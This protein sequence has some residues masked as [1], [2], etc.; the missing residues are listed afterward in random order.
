MDRPTGAGRPLA[1]APPSLYRWGCKHFPSLAAAS[2]V[3]ALLVV[4]FGGIVR[5]TGSGLGCPD[6]PLCHGRV[7][8]PADVKAWIEYLHRLSVTLTSIFVVLMAA[9]AVVQHGFRR[10]L[11]LPLFAPVLLIVQ[12]IFGAATVLSELDAGVAVTHT[13]IAMAFV[14]VLALLTCGSGGWSTRV[15]EPLKA[16]LRGHRLDRHLRTAMLLLALLTYLLLLSGSYVYRSGA[17]LACLSYPFCGVAPPPGDSWALQDIH[18]LHRY[19]ALATGLL[20]V[21]ALWTAWRVRAAN[22][23]PLLLLG[24]FAALFALQVALGASNVLFLL[25]GWARLSHLVIASLTFTVAVMAAGSLWGVRIASPA[26][27]GKG[28][29]PKGVASHA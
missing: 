28:E 6:W 27:P 10:S 1:W 13:A 2:L 25:P 20:A 12:I 22:A 18:M 19:A 23:A 17:P 3:T 21:Y 7:I 26:L 15:T 24:G 29:A 4:I 8:P 5:V 11:L 16:A 14:G 9:T